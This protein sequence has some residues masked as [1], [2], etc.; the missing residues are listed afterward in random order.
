MTRP[1]W[2]VLSLVLAAQVSP[3]QE[4]REYTSKSGNFRML[5]PD[6]WKRGGRPPENFEVLLTRGVSAIMIAA[7]ETNVTPEDIAEDV[8]SNTKMLMDGAWRES[9]RELAVAG[10]RAI[11]DRFN[12]HNQ[13]FEGDLVVAVFCHQGIAY[14]V[15]AV[16]TNIE[17]GDVLSDFHFILKNWSYSRD[18]DDWLKK[19][20]GKPAPLAMLGGRVE[21]TLNRPRWRETTLE[22]ETSWQTL[23]HAG[24]ALFSGGGWI[25]VEVVKANGAQD[26][27]LNRLGHDLA[28]YFTDSR[29]AV[30]RADLS[31]GAGWCVSVQGKLKGE[32]RYLRGFAAVEGDLVV[33]AWIECQASRREDTLRDWKQL[34]SSLVFHPQGKGPQPPAWTP[35]LDSGPASRAE[36]DPAH[37]VSRPLLNFA[38]AQALLAL[39]PDLSRAAF[40]GEGRSYV[41]DLSTGRRSLLPE[42]VGRGTAIAWSADGRLLAYSGDKA[43]TVVNLQDGKTAKFEIRAS[44]L[45][46][47]GA[48]FDLFAA[49]TG[50]DP[51][52]RF[53]TS[54]L[55]RVPRDGGKRDT[56]V[57]FPLSRVT[58]VA[59]SPDGK[60]LAVGTNERLPRRSESGANLFVGAIDGTGMTRVTEGAEDVTA[61]A[62]TADGASLVFLRRLAVDGEGHVPSWGGPRD[63]WRVPAGGGAAV[64]LT[65]CGTVTGFVLAGDRVALEFNDWRLPEAARGVFEAR[66]HDLEK[67]T[68]ALPLPAPLDR[69][70]HSRAIQERLAPLLARKSIGEIVPTAEFVAELAKGFAAAAGDVCETRLDFSAESLDRFS[71]LLSEID[72]SSPLLLAAAG[73]YY[74]ETLRLVSDAQWSLGPEPLQAWLKPSDPP[75]SLV[76]DVVQPWADVAA[77]LAGSED[78]WLLDADSARRESRRKHI[79]LVHPPSGAQEAVRAFEGKGLEDARRLLDAGEVARA[80][81]IF[82]EE[83]RRFPR[84]DELALYVIAACDAAGLEDEA[85][86]FVADAVD[87]GTEAIALLV[88]QADALAKSEPGK[89]RELYRRAAHGRWGTGEAFIKL[90]KSYDATGERALAESCW[91]QGWRGADEGQQA[92]LK[93]LMGALK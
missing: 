19:N 14:R 26:Q 42:E 40:A 49:V 44:S 88:R 70:G 64:N 37:T 17:D 15:V 20:E 82:L 81:P 31:S 68:A 78:A 27:E 80:L 77:V 56:L 12:V 36:L 83:L 50:P 71:A 93:K 16:S 11:E 58:C 23:D 61:V 5:Y 90:G 35:V 85:R 33:R 43:V 63:L 60:R 74:G 21:F 39:S 91:R 28:R 67:A 76:A 75:A 45:A 55:L 87:A 30:A 69:A 13:G 2:I 6:S 8:E 32:P 79:L 73:A 86:R 65:R 1:L 62:W 4:N 34:A 18:R 54:T 25:S 41:E 57:S 24:F 59:V 29:I 47:G 51:G 7:T 92:E 9:R 38:R 22:D 3:A 46:F 48:G 66:I 53:H 72:V 89:A 10:E 84:S 52:A